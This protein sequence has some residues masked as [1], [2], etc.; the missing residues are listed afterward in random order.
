M[1]SKLK[2][3][4]NA[5]LAFDKGEEHFGPEIAHDIRV[6]A[7]NTNQSHA[8]LHQL[9]W[10]KESF[11][12]T[13]KN[14]A[15]FEFQVLDDDEKV[16]KNNLPFF[17]L[18]TPHLEYKQD[19]QTYFPSLDRNGI[20]G[21]IQFSAWWSGEDVCVYD[22]KFTFNRKELVLAFA[23]KLGG[24]HID[25]NPS[26]LLQSIRD[27]ED[28]IMGYHMYSTN[29]ETGESTKIPHS[30]SPFLSSV[31]QIAH[32]LF[33]TVKNIGV[34]SVD[35]IYFN[36]ISEYRLLGHNLDK[37]DKGMKCQQLL[38]SVDD[39]SRILVGQNDK[40]IAFGLSQVEPDNLGSYL[41]YDYAIMANSDGKFSALE[42]GKAM[43]SGLFY[44][45]NDSFHLCIIKRE[46]GI[47][48]AF[49]HRGRVFYISKYSPHLPLYNLVAFKHPGAEIKE[50][51]IINQTVIYNWGDFT[52]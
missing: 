31:R 26:Q 44:E 45:A 48:V 47:K 43:V 11:V 29:N 10:D 2:V 28:G 24:S 32:E 39:C 50:P 38:A 20:M 25:P 4:A 30:V 33:L 41:E 7:H 17:Y 37:W 18:T 14:T 51:Q 35:D 15:V 36:N 8:L 23:N 6:I 1:K 9:G 12:S 16:V 19:F 52:P 21:S 46:Q 5:C 13:K 42:R 3:L 49:L 27:K 22:E 40:A 34:I